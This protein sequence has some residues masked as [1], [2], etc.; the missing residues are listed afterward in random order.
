MNFFSRPDQ[1]QLQA[2]HSDRQQ[3]ADRTRLRAEVG[4]NGRQNEKVEEIAVRL[5]IEPGVTSLSW[6]IVPSPIE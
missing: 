3:G 1:G 5:S 6:S 2:I 4:T